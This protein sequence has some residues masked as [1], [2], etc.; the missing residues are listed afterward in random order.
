MPL[1]TG[2][3]TPAKGPSVSYAQQVAEAKALASTSLDGALQNLLS[4]EKTARLARP[5]RCRPIPKSRASSTVLC[6]IAAYFRPIHAISSC[7]STTS[8]SP[9]H[10]CLASFGLSTTSSS[11]ALTATAVRSATP[12]ATSATAN[13]INSKDEELAAAKC[14]P[15]D[16]RDYVILKPQWILEHITYIVRC[17]CCFVLS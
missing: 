12:A 7:S 16:P 3:E 6:S 17:G 15:V 10:A 9:S 11:S 4:H 13:Y 5:P 1:P 8:S 2:I 14:G